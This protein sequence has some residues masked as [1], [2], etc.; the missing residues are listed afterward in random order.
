MSDI[1]RLRTLYDLYRNLLTRGIADV[2]ATTWSGDPISPN[3]IPSYVAAS[4]ASIQSMHKTIVP[5]IDQQFPSDGSFE[6]AFQLKNKEQV[7]GKK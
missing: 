4:S 1:E 2:R 6:Q 5:Y 3:S 7:E